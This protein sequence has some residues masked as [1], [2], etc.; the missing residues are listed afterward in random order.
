MGLP[1]ST[2][3]PSQA[4]TRALAMSPSSLLPVPFRGDSGTSGHHWARRAPKSPQG[5]GPGSRLLRDRAPPASGEQPAAHR[6][7]GGWA[8][9]ARTWIWRTPPCPSDSGSRGGGRGASTLGADASD[10]SIPF[11]DL[12]NL[13]ASLG[14]Q[15]WPVPSPDPSPGLRAWWP[16]RCP[17]AWLRGAGLACRF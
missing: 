4:H 3:P 16:V 1:G 2:S 17:P 15:C 14:G 5:V 7:R 11:S 9:G 6:V 13:L 10:P 8:A 12:P